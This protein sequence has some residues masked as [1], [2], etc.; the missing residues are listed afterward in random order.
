MKSDQDYRREAMQLWRAAIILAFTAYMA[1]LFIKVTSMPP[2]IYQ[3]VVTDCVMAGGEWERVYHSRDSDKDMYGCVLD[4]A[5][6]A[7]NPRSPQE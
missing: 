7:I 4:G 1:A 3:R 5:V 2:G 6:L